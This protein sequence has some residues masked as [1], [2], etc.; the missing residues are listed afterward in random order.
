[1]PYLVAAVVLVGALSLLNLLLTLGI[2]RR[3]RA[4][5]LRPGGNA[6]HG[7]DPFA[8]KPGSP[9]GEF[10]ALTSE[11]DPVT[12]ETLTGVVGFFSAGCEPCHELLPDFVAR[13]RELGRDHVLAVVGGDDRD[14]V[15]ALTPVARVVLAEPD[16]GPVARAFRNEWTPALY[17]VGPDG[18][19]AATAAR[20]EELPVPAT[21]RA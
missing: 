15:A 1:M 20:V 18:R 16:G 19:I 6:G 21:G 14:L 11:G 10:T 5:A 3:M 13:A 4:D 8:L 17:L 12:R 7:V 9:V 2:L